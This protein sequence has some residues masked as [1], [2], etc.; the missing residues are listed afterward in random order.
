MVEALH[1]L[2]YTI[3]CIMLRSVTSSAEWFIYPVSAFVYRLRECVCTCV[4]VCVHQAGNGWDGAY[5]ACEYTEQFDQ[6]CHRRLLRVS[7]GGRDA[8]ERQ[9][10]HL[11]KHVGKKPIQAKCSAVYIQ[12]RHHNFKKENKQFLYIYI[13]GHILLCSLKSPAI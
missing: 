6:S 2:C 4:Y 3:C 12:I 1:P 13:N 8:D 10:L 11:L 9:Y 5:L 7:A